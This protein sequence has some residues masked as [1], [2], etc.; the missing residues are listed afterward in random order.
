MSNSKDNLFGM[1]LVSIA[2]APVV[3]GS[4]AALASVAIY[5]RLVPIKRKG[6]SPYKREK[7]SAARK[8]IQEIEAMPAFGSTGLALP[9]HLFKEY[10]DLLALVDSLSRESQEPTL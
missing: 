9:A 6:L 10:T 5:H 7:D 2:G 4:L 1:L 3:L 8:R